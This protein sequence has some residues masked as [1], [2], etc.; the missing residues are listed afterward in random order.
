MP[1]C[2]IV[3]NITRYDPVYTTYNEVEPNNTT[4]TANNLSTSV[5]RVIGYIGNATDVDYYKLSLD[6]GQTITVSMSGPAGKDY[7]LY[8]QNYSGVTLVYSSTFGA[9]E[10]IIY[11]RG[12]P[13]DSTSAGAGGNIINGPMGPVTTGTTD[14]FYIKVVG[15]LGAFSTVYPYYLNITYKNP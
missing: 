5:N 1:V 10:G 14:I 3:T 8:F 9:N 7:D 4:A 12:I 6:R 2:S 13:N 15:Y 11:Y